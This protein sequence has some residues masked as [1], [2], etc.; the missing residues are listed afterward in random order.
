MPCS[1]RDPVTWA[2]QT[3]CGMYLAL[4]GGRPIQSRRARGGVV[5]VVLFNADDAHAVGAVWRFDLD[6]FSDPVSDQR[7]PQRR[8]VAASSR[9][10]ICLGRTDDSVGLLIGP[11]FAEVNRA[12]HVDDAGPRLGLDQNVV[13]DD[14]L[15]LVDARL[16]HALLVLRRVV[17][18]V[19]GEVAE[20]PGRLDLGHDRRPPTRGQLVELLANRHEPLRGDVDVI[21]HLLESSAQERD[22][23]SPLAGEVGAERRVGG[24]PFL[25]C[26]RA[27]RRLLLTVGMLLMG[28]ALVGCAA[29]S[30]VGTS[31]L[32]LDQEV[33]THAAAAGAVLGIGLM[34][35]AVNPAGNVGWVRAGILYVFVVLAFEGGSDFLLRASLHLRPGILCPALTL[36]PLPTYPGRPKLMPTPQRKNT[37]P[38]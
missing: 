21:G 4:R 29:G 33:G 14:R 32:P 31:L 23:T 34:A 5:V 27:M 26:R 18:E 16:H 19:L 15:E 37:G 1:A 9:L 10:W 2:A 36:L 3:G 6:P 35:A 12:A 30:L 8:L 28:M 24:R 11:V 7:L 38:R 22:F 13:L 17:L 20:L 25:Y